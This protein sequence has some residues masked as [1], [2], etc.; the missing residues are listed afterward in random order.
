MF[1]R[2]ENLKNCLR[3]QYYGDYMSVL[4][5]RVAEPEN[6]ILAVSGSPRKNGNSDYM[7]KTLFDSIENSNVKKKHISLG[8]YLYQSCKGCE[9]CRKDG[10]CTG[11]QDGMNSIY[12]EIISARGLVL[13]SPSHNYNVTGW[14]KAFIDRLY[15]FYNFENPRPGAWS[16]QLSDQNRFAVVMGVCE[17]DSEE[18]LGFTLKGMTLPLKALGYDIIAE[19]AVLNSFAKGS[20]KSKEKE[21]S[22]ISDL[23]ERINTFF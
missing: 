17:Q 2:L 11:M 4:E 14:M 5:R 7:I 8:D 9:R 3:K 21:L 15:C 6:K 22:E 16:S 13:V 1:T 12:S 20:I 10:I 19:K 23:G 18:D